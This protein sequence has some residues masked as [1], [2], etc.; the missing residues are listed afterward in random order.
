M[1]LNCGI[2]LRFIFLS[3]K[4]N[5]LLFTKQN[6]Q[7]IK[8][9]KK[10]SNTR[11]ES[12]VWALSKLSKPSKLCIRLKVTLISI[13][14]SC[15]SVE[16]WKIL[17]IGSTFEIYCLKSFQGTLRNVSAGFSTS[18]E[19]AGGVAFRR[20]NWKWVTQPFLKK[21][22]LFGSPDSA[23]FFHFFCAMFRPSVVKNNPGFISVPV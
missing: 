17:S 18:W 6:I 10:F 8:G 9:N 12:Q 15:M 7:K 13:N 4:L 16:S 21:R 22:L 11:K 20:N 19:C 2:T 23:A 1:S 3:W 14:S 5:S